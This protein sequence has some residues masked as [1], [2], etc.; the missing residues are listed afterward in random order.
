MKHCS[1]CGEPI[2]R[3]RLDATKNK[4]KTCIKHMHQHDVARVAGFNPSESKMRGNIIIA[5]QDTVSDLIDKSWRAG[6]GVSRGVKFHTG[7]K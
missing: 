5:D 3:L 2:E 4:A 1:V 7:R 6:T